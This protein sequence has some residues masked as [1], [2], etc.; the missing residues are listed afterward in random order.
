MGGLQTRSPSAAITSLAAAWS[1]AGA[2][3]GRTYNLTFNRVYPGGGGGTRHAD[4]SLGYGDV[5]IQPY[6]R[7]YGPITG[8]A[9]GLRHRRWAGCTSW[10]RSSLPLA[11]TPPTSSAST[12]RRTRPT[13]TTTPPSRCS[14][15][16][17]DEHRLAG[18][19]DG[20][21]L[22]HHVPHRHQ[23]DGEHAGPGQLAGRLPMTTPIPLGRG[24]WRLTLH[25]R[26]FQDQSWQST[27]SPSSACQRPAP[28]RPTRST[29]SA[30][31]TFTIDGR[32]R[33]DAARCK[34]SPPTSSPGAGTRPGK[35]RALH[36]RASSAQSEDQVSQQIARRHVHLPR[37]LRHV[38]PAFRHRTSARPTPT[39]TPSSPRW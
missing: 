1:G 21:R 19:A 30:Q 33:R 8:A 22:D 32:R 10:C 26:Q 9:G 15:D 29:Q 18:P 38:G 16:R 4:R 5:P 35:G 6:L 12:P 34:N 13:S 27:C 17:L 14:T 37:L 3:G 7:I 28:G 20:P 2:G 39:R 11:S 25:K 31:L 24:R 36:P 23:H